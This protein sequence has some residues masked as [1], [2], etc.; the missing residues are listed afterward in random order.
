MSGKL[1]PYTDIKALIFS[2][3]LGYN[4]SQMFSLRGLIMYRLTVDPEINSRINV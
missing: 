3:L 2:A 1:I 4:R